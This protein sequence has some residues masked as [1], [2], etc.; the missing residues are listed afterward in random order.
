MYTLLRMYWI[1]APQ[2]CQ[3]TT[4]GNCPRCSLSPLSKER[5]GAGLTR[6]QPGT[7]TNSLRNP[8]MDTNGDL[9]VLDTRV[10]ADSSMVDTIQKIEELGQERCNTFFQ[11][12]LVDCT[13]P[14]Q[15]KI[16]KANLPLFG[17]HAH[18]EKSRGQKHLKAMKRDRTLF[19]TLYIVCQVRQISMVDFFSHENQPYPPSPSEYSSMRSGTKAYLLVCLEDL[20]P[21]HDT[22]NQQDVHMVI[23]DAGWWC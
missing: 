10:V 4:C 6:V 13:T 8:F 7:A 9:L 21:T 17:R 16:T 12:R 20:I 3:L 11:D 23:L 22:V 15:D 5:K 18:Q 19:S 1:V 2:F 14:L